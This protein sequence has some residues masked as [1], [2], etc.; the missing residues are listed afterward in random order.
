MYTT[1]YCPLSWT[2]VIITLKALNY[3]CISHGA[4]RVFSNHHKC[5]S[6]LFQIHLNTYVMGPRPLKNVFTRTLHEGIDF[7]RQNLTST[8]VGL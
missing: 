7:R 6:Y 3:F 4:Q 1:E 5:L 2:T 8:D